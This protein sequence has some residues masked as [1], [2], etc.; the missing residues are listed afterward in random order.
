MSTFN[1]SDY[2]FNIRLHDLEAKKV[3]RAN[4]AR[5]VKYFVDCRSVL[6]IATGTG[7]FLD[8]LREKQIQAVGVDDDARVV[9]SAAARGHRVVHKDI[10]EYLAET[11]ES[12]DGALCSHVIEHLPFEAVTKLIEGVSQRLNSGG[13]FVLAF[14]NPKA[15]R[16]HLYQFWMDPQ[17]VRFY[18]GFLIKGV[19][20]WYGFQIVS[21]S[22][23]MEYHNDI[24]RF[25]PSKLIEDA[26]TLEQDRKQKRRLRRL[27]KF[28]GGVGDWVRI[29]LGIKALAADVVVIR[30]M[31]I[32]MAKLIDSYDMEVRIVA[33]R[34]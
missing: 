19:L 23:F 20:E 16:T 2:E 26:R 4:L 1:Y 21:H 18:D 11:E 33:R 10:L 8:L 34:K 31:I 12:F 29:G 6:D 17:H 32:W 7:V 3:H 15:L 24:D 5:F 22:D 27:S 28:W 25:A 30:R 13:I 9:E 14:P